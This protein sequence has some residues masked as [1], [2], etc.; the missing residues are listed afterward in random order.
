[1]I[2]K[3]L[4]R[5]MQLRRKYSSE[6][7]KFIRNRNI[8]NI[9]LN[10]EDSDHKQLN[11]SG[12]HLNQEDTRKPT[13]HDSL[14]TTHEP[15]LSEPANTRTPAAVSSST[16]LPRCAPEVD[17]QTLLKAKERAVDEL[18]ENNHRIEKYL[19]QI[20]EEVG[21]RKE[22]ERR[23]EKKTTEVEIDEDFETLEMEGFYREPI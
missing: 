16:P 12:R 2:A 1:M 17:L 23:I 19:E 4:S 10:Y 7:G 8:Y 22:K 15:F 20:E 13:P 6:V 18:N 9:S 3:L 21:K 14:Q 11:V 5:E